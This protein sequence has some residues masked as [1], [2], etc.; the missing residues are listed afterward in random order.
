MTR[1]HKNREILSKLKYHH[2][3]YLCSWCPS[4]THSFTL[5]IE[6][7]YR[8]L[9]FKT[10]IYVCSWCN[11]YRIIMSI[12]S[13]PCPAWQ[14]EIHLQKSCFQQV[15]SRLSG[16]SHCGLIIAGHMDSYPCLASLR[17]FFLLPWP[18]II[19]NY[20]TI[21]KDNYHMESYSLKIEGPWSTISD[22]W[23]W[24]SACVGLSD[25]ASF[26]VIVPLLYSYRHC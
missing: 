12:G 23:P 5:T 22:K 25:N 4:W 7:K 9:F 2:R 16:P 15:Y 18:T 21:I 24:G 1:K 6:P 26:W 8:R 13:L 11:F 20:I 3:K 14:Q 17:C 10:Y 19:W